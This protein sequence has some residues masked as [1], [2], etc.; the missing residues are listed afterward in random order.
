MHMQN[1]KQPSGGIAFNSGFHP[2]T[3]FEPCHLRWNLIKIKPFLAAIDPAHLRRVRCVGMSNAPNFLERCR[4]GH[5]IV[6]DIDKIHE[7]LP[8]RTI[9]L[10]H[11]ERTHRV[12]P[13]KFRV[14]TSFPFLSC[15]LRR[16]S[17]THT[18]MQK[19]S[20]PGN[21]P[22]PLVL[23]VQHQGFRAFVRYLTKMDFPQKYIAC[24]A[25]GGP[26]ARCLMNATRQVDRLC[27][28]IR[29]FGGN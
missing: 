17:S 25:I 15:K 27:D 28:D 18:D 13:L 3:R 26:F 29:M 9:I 4:G 8:F 20:F 5:A 19:A 21:P 16:C 6:H 1:A 2:L 23:T 22:I 11:L 12:Q 7:A 24:Y 10:G 14:K